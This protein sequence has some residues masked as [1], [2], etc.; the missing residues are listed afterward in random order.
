MSRGRHF[1]AMSLVSTCICKTCRLLLHPL[2]Y[3]AIKQQ[4]VSRLEKEEDGDLNRC[5]EKIK[6]CYEY[7]IGRVHLITSYRF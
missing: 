2:L 3:T 7:E 4:L 6:M 1:P 5:E